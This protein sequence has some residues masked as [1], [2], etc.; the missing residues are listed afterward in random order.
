MILI[1]FEIK[2]IMAV[3]AFYFSAK[4]VAWTAPISTLLKLIGVG[5]VQFT[6]DKMKRENWAS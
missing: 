4:R 2:V 1:N 5:T 6:V 3:Q